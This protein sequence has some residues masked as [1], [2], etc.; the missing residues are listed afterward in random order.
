MDTKPTYGELIKKV[1]QLEQSLSSCNQRLDAMQEREKKY[2]TLV[3]NISDG[4]VIID[5]QG[6][7]TYK[8]PI[9]SKL[10]GW[11]ADDLVGR[12][13]YFMVHPDERDMIQNELQAIFD[14]ENGKTRLEF[15]YRRKDGSFSPVELTAVNMFDSPFV[16]GVLVSCKDI[17]EKKKTEN[18]LRESEKRYRSIMDAMD[19]MIY[20]CSPDLR[21]EYMNP[22]M[23]RRVGYDAVGEHCHKVVHE[24]DEQ[25]SWCIHDRVMVG[26]YVKNEVI[27][28]K[29]NKSFHISNSPIFHVDG[30]VSKLTVCRDVTEFKKLEARLQHAQKLETIGTLSGGIAHDFN[31]ILVPILSH[32]E[33]LL[34]QMSTDSPESD[35]LHGIYSGALRARE[36]VKQ[37]LVFARQNANEFQLMRISPL[38]KE[39]L[40]LMQSVIPS[41]VTVRQSVRIDCRPVMADPTQIHQVVINLVTNAIHA[42][43]NEGGELEITLNEVSIDALDIIPLELSPGHYVCLT[44]GDTGVGMDKEMTQKIFD[45]F[46]TTKETGQGTGM[47]LSVVRG[48]MAGMDGGILVHSEPGAG[49]VFKAFFP[50]V[51]KYRTG[52]DNDDVEKSVSEGTERILLV[53]DEEIVVKT[54]CK[55]LEHLG[56]RVVAHTGG[57]DALAAFLSS[58]EAFDLVITDLIM[59]DLSGEKLS[60][61]IA[62]VRPDLPILLITGSS[63]GISEQEASSLGVKGC[64]SKP[65][66][67]HDLSQ[68]IRKALD[69]DKVALN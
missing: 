18:E 47:G 53:D 30:S 15:R 1:Q 9:V 40:K 22:A 8:S 66:M 63:R 2:Y 7:I 37:I 68:R 20:I 35:S 27:S 34:E 61:K 3:S 69:K 42:M 48:I 59:P 46:F 16:R 54:Y 58:P 36:L 13:V 49:S 41:A 56:Y 39:A 57:R 44:V 33:L 60:A 4:M 26:E 65:L 25:C 64:I 11:N 45:P 6:I 21:I 50:V 67:I 62:K 17:S 32:A 43:E 24:L 51:D 55:I 52:E 5:K 12:H 31:N 14:L 29:D 10:S 23:L 38:V 19:E 28:P